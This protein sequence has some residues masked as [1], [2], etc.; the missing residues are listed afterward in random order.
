MVTFRRR[1]N[2]YSIQVEQSK[3]KALHIV[4]PAIPAERNLPLPLLHGASLWVIF[5]LSNGWIH[6]INNSLPN[7]I[8]VF[9]ETFLN[10]PMPHLLN[11]CQ[12]SANFSV[13]M[14]YGRSFRGRVTDIEFNTINAY[15]YVSFVK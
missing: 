13:M 7:A 4:F 1:Q 3:I 6:T 14:Y 11:S 12:I 9:H 10:Q 8:R 5:I 2:V 15:T